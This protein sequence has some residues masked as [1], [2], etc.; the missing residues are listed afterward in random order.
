MRSIILIAHNIRSTHNVGS[1]LRSCDGFG[2]EQVIFT[3]YTPYP[4]Q[5]HDTRLPHIYR[6]LTDAIAKTALGAESMVKNRHD[7]DIIDTIASLKADG[8]TIIAL[9][10][11][12]GSIVLPDYQPPHNI[13][14][15]IGEEVHGITPELI[16]L[17]DNII[18]IPMY[19]S[20]ESFNVSVATGIALFH[21]RTSK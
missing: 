3:G 8:Y 17:C 5:P 16:A 10:Q 9:E 18:E 12:K 2:V 15:L 4:K 7:D 19:G 6:K 21:L 20:K 13:A 1:L 11:A 14:L